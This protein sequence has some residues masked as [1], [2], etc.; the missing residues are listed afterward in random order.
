M[1]PIVSE[2]WNGIEYFLTEYVINSKENIDDSIMG[3]QVQTKN[4]KEIQWQV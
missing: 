1:Y 4:L 2:A 3:E